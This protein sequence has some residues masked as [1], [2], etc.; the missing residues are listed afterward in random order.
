MITRNLGGP[1]AYRSQPGGL[2]PTGKALPASCCLRL[3]PPSMEGSS[4][5]PQRAIPLLNSHGLLR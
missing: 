2:A 1:V 3:T 4:T 5:V